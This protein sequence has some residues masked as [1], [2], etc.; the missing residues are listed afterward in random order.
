MITSMID[1]IKPAIAIPL[2]LLNKP[3]KENRAPK[4]QINQ[5]TPGTQLKI[6]EIKAKI[7][8]AVPI[9]FDLW[10]VLLITIG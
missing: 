6:A 4:N 8:P 7:N 9:P 2:G 3:M 10:T 1:R 5:P